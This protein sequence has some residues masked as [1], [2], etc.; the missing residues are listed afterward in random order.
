MTALLPLLRCP[1]CGGELAATG[2]GLACA[3]CDRDYPVV[4][5]IPR[6]VAADNYAASFGLQW[7]K[8]A[9]TQLDSTTGTELT[10]RRFLA[11][12][13]WTERELRGALV[14]DAGCGSGRFAEIALDLGAEVVAIDYSSAVDAC[15]QNLAGRDRL[16]V[17]QA[18]IYALP[19]APE[20]FDFVYSFGVIQHTPDVQRTVA[21]LVRQVRPGG[22]LALDVYKKGLGEVLHPKLWLRPLTRRLPPER[23][24]PWIERLAP[25]LLEVSRAVSRIPLVGRVARRAIPVANYEGVHPLTEEQLRDF[26]IL[27][28]FDWLSPRYDQPQTAATLQRW[29]RALGLDEIEVLHPAHLTARAR[30]PS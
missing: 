18:D 1:G 14:L 2:A 20:R 6:F 13:G 22:R 23:L 11:Q 27:D 26:A 7:N 9:R 24:F 12:S 16:H 5:G 19:F 29:L 3:R 25:P 10:R 8:F 4:D 30:K 17:V 21:S 15:A 28:T